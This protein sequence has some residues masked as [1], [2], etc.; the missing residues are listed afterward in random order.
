M[1]LD[2]WR[3]LAARIDLLWGQP[4]MT[5]TREIAYFEVLEGFSADEVET[6]IR[7]LLAEGREFTPSASVLIETIGGGDERLSWG[8]AWRAI[9]A[10]IRKNPRGEDVGVFRFLETEHPLYVEFVHEESLDRLRDINTEDSYAMGRLER[11]WNAMVADWRKGEVRRK[12]DTLA[13]NGRSA[14]RQIGASVKE[15]ERGG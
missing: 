11:V 3:P 8:A 15:I 13:L 14:P 4:K 10:A 12:A 1:T 6:A 7:T 2:E 5:E 9:T